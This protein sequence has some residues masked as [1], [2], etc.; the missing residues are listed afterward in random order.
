M[1]S[2]Y[3]NTIPELKKDKAKKAKANEFYSAMAEKYNLGSGPV[4]A[5]AKQGPKE[6]SNK[7][8]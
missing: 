7:I 2:D 1:S 4:E 5:K 8:D 6:F 3:S